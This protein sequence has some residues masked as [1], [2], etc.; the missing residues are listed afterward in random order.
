MTIKE[1]EYKLDNYYNH[2]ALKDAMNRLDILKAEFEALYDAGSA[3]NY[4]GLPHSP[5]PGNPPLEAVCKLEDK[6]EQLQ[7]LIEKQRRTILR[8]THIDELIA[9]AL[10]KLNPREEEII[11]FKHCERDD[12]K[13]IARRMHYSESRI[14]HIYSNALYKIRIFLE[15]NKVSTK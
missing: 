4:N 15:N 9:I 11:H 7:R 8:M 2:W 10:H 3:I 13:T 6:P 5:S 1:L 14:R 12:F